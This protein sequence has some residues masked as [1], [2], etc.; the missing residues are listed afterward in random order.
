VTPAQAAKLSA[1]LRTSL[2]QSTQEL[3]GSALVLAM[4]LEDSLHAAE[5]SLALHALRQ[6]KEVSRA[7]HVMEV[8]SYVVSFGSFVV[9]V[10]VS[11]CAVAS[12]SFRPDA[13]RLNRLVYACVTEPEAYSSARLKQTKP[14]GGAERAETFGKN[15][16]RLTFCTI[17]IQVSYLLWGLMQ[18][19]IMTRPYATGELFKSSK[20]LVFAN[21]FL[22]LLVAWLGVVV[23]RRFKLESTEHD[24]PLYKFAHSSI[25]NILSSVSQYEALKYVSFP[26]QVVAKSCKMVPVM[27]MG[28]AVSG[29]RYTAFEY[30]VA[31]AIT[32]GAAIFKLNEDSDAPVKNTQFIGIIFIVAYM[33]CDSFTS[34]WQSKV[35]KQYG[36]T[37][38]VMMMYA[39][40]FSSGFTALGLVLNLEIISVWSFVEANPA[41]VAH[42]GIMAICSAV[43]QLFIFYTISKYGPLVFATIQTVRQLLSIVL[44]IL[45]FAHPINAMEMLGI[46]IVFVALTSQIYQKYQANKAKEQAKVVAE[47]VSPAELEERAGSCSDEERINAVQGLLKR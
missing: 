8:L 25:S 21:R 4:M 15:A 1:G 3:L 5:E 35:F 40:L 27:L 33:A 24:T 12:P 22:A 6:L 13:S 41:I 17:G 44:S 26:T 46:A 31:I 38:M 11:K 29:K 28:Y 43:G 45:F 39:N 10:W 2:L 19:R 16:M 14:G 20:F 36:V 42:I 37:S 32:S 18:E 9:F 47:P 34:N 23:I 30:A 7:E